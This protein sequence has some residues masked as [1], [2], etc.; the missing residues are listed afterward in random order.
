MP[1]RPALLAGDDAVRQYQ[2]QFSARPKEPQV[3]R[4]EKDVRRNTLDVRKDPRQS[5]V[6]KNLTE[7]ATPPWSDVWWVTQG[8]MS[9][10]NVQTDFLCELR[11]EGVGD[12]MAERGVGLFKEPRAASVFVN[13]DC[14]EAYIGPTSAGFANQRAVTC[15]EVDNYTF[16]RATH[17]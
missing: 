9:H 13:V 7:V 2:P 8:G 11:I 5:S 14:N 3:L 17:R 1:K 16:G 10:A 4:D 15:P 6:L 12:M